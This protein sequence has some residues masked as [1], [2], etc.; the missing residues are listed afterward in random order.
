M[1]HGG[2]REGAGR[3]SVRI[4]LGE[5]EKLCGLQCTDEDLAAY[6]DVN[7]KTIER[8]RRKPAFAV[9]ME[10]GRA[11]GRLSVRRSL[12][13]QAAEGNTAAAIFLAKNLLGYRDV[14]NNQLSG[15]DGGP[16]ALQNTLDLT[17]LSTEEFE[18]VLAL[19]D[20]AERPP[21]ENK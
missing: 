18:Q 1:M 17:R 14:R 5:L 4:D 20:K 9:A 11:K 2:K 15:P 12:F 16:I 7:V 10:R 6:F 3:K 13:K 21:G 8:R 19:M